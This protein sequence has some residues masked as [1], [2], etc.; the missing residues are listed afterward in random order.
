VVLDAGRV[1]LARRAQSPWR[2]RWGAPG[3]FCEAGEHPIDTATREVLEETGRRVEVTGYLGVWVDE[4]SDQPGEPGN[5][6]INVSYYVARLAGADVGTR[7]SATFDPA[8]VSE[9]DWFD[10]DGLPAPLAPPETLVAVL[11]AARHAAPSQVLDRPSRR[12]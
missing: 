3:G 2:H 9:L 5:D 6:V 4:Y 12:P 8:E 11:A 1:L 10:L 7:E